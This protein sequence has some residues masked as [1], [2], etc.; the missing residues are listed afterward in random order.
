MKRTHHRLPAG[1][2]ERGAPAIGD[3]P[4]A[5]FGEIAQIVAPGRTE[6]AGLIAE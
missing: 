3:M 2:W 6:K 4:E 1:F 5:T